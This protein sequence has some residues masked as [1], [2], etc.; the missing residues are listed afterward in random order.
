MSKT[1]HGEQ[2]EENKRDSRN[3]RGGRYRH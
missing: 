1:H 3:R 2:K